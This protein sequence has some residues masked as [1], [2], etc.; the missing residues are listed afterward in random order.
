MEVKAHEAYIKQEYV[1]SNVV[2]FDWG[3]VKIHTEDG[4]IRTY[5]MTVF[6]AAYSNLRWAK[7][8]PK[9]DSQCFVEAH[10]DFFEY[11]DGSFAQVVYDN[12]R[13]AVK[14][15]VSKNE[16]EPTYELL[17]L[18]L[19]YRYK[20]RFCNILSGN[21]KGLLNIVLKL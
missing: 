12:M 1:P 18:A 7:L 20:F 8:F 19:Y 13:V 11:T 3:T 2:E 17:K 5:Q 16:K 21:E 4:I 6:T 14:K 15:F 10:S 9:Q